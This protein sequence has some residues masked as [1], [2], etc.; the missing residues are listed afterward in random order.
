MHKMGQNTKMRGTRSEE[1]VTLTPRSSIPD[2]RT[3]LLIAAGLLLLF[4]TAP[5]HAAALLLKDGRVL[6]GPFAEV[7]GVAESGLNPKG[8]AGEVAVTPLV[9]VD[10]GLRRTFIHNFQIQQV[11]EEASEKTVRIRLWQDVAEQGSGVGR[12]GRALR[13]TPFDEHGRRI[14]EMPG[15]DGLLSV[16]QGITEITPVYTKVE[17]LSGPTKSIVWDMRIATSSIPRETLDTILA[18]TVPQK[19]V[20]ARLQVVRLYLQADRYRDAEQELE[21]V[22]RDFPDMKNLADE[23]KQLRQLGA[24]L[25]LKEL[26]LRAKVGQ[27]QLARVMLEKFPGEGVS[28]TTLEQVRGLLAKFSTDDARR[29]DLLAKLNAQVAHVADDYER[30]LA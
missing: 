26:Q 2:P 7:A 25:V 6:E 8:N 4:S 22:I 23:V 15:R 16:V 18:M 5:A 19:D 27:P 10:D 17:G 24:R 9:V 13:I 3:S 28:G 29:R 14:Y 21:E 12:I 11:L 1:R 20:D 30:R